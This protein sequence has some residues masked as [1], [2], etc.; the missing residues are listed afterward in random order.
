M[1]KKT[2]TKKNQANANQHSE[3]DFLLF[4]NY[5]HS[6]GTDPEIFETGALYRPPR[7]KYFGKRFLLA[8]SNFL[9]FYMQESLPM[10][11]YQFF[12]ICKHFD[13]E[14]EKTVDEKRKTEKSWTLFYNRLF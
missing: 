2:Q 5:S 8:F 14:T 10:K 1:S 3:A 6:S 11:S 4:E 12:K 9:H 7:L 13:K